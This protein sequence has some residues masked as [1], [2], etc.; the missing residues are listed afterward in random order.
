MLA[1]ARTIAERVYVFASPVFTAGLPEV[2][3]DPANLRAQLARTV[4][5]CERP[6]ASGVY[7]SFLGE[8]RGNFSNFT[9]LS[10]A[11]HR[12]LGDWLATQIH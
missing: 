11:G 12:A 6:A 5:A 1:N 9:H 10:Q 8:Q 4:T 3:E 2:G 7:A